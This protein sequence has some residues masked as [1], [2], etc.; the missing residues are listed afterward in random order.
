MKR[1]V[2]IM[3]ILVIMLN[4]SDVA[5]AK[6]VNSLTQLPRMVDSYSAVALKNIKGYDKDTF[7]PVQ[8]RKGQKIIIVEREYFAGY[9]YIILKGNIYIPFDNSSIKIIK[10]VN[11]KADYDKYHMSQVLYKEL[12]Y[13]GKNNYYYN[14]YKTAAINYEKQHQED[15]KYLFMEMLANTL[16]NQPIY[17]R[18]IE[19]PGEVTF[20][21]W[22]QEGKPT[23]DYGEWKCTNQN[24]YKIDIM[25]PKFHSEYFYTN[26]RN[27][28]DIKIGMNDPSF[29]ERINLCDRLGTAYDFVQYGTNVGYTIDSKHKIKNIFII[30]DRKYSFA[31]TI[32]VFGTP[33]S[34]KY[35]TKGVHEYHA[36]YDQNKRNGFKVIVAF[37]QFKGNLKYIVKVDE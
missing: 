37:D 21:Q 18:G 4:I 12:Q 33:S 26:N 10:H 36:I 13:I 15:V 30:P 25:N 14:R 28:S 27:I 11:G 17:G 2:Q 34:Y 22:L 3:I 1:L 24:K 7:S 6:S 5:E 35:I 16:H 8:I 31:Q 9:D 29:T 20:D 23:Y 32:K 19:S